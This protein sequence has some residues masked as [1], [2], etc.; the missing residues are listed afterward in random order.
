MG[1]IAFIFPGQGSQTVGHGEKSC[2]C[3]NSSGKSFES[4]AYARLGQISSKAHFR[5][6]TDELTMTRMHNA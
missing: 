5:M 3:L 4:G 2:R 6:S 1:K